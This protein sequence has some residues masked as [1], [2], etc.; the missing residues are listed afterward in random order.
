[1]TRDAE[2]EH[3]A[4]VANE[5]IEWARAP[6]HDA[7]WAY[8]EAFIAFVGP[9][10]GEALDVG[11]GEGRISRELKA[12]GY[13]VTALDPVP[14]MVVAAREAHSAIDYAIAPGT[15]LPFEA[16][17]FDLA[18]AYNVLMD[19]EDVPATMN[20]IRRVLRP[21][22][23]LVISIVHPFSDRGSFANGEDAPP[24]V[25]QDGYFGLKRFDGMV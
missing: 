9:G 4:R 18:V 15:D 25:I 1:M 8:R 19:V 20:E 11:C 12:L 6:N 7:F 3:W 2:S 21:A 22:G 13:K 23:M 14:A 17:S 16:A 5:W 24:F 10:K